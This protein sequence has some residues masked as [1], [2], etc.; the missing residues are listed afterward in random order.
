VARRVGRVERID[1]RVHDVLHHHDPG[2]DDRPA[3]LFVDDDDH[4]GPLDV[5]H[6]RP[7]DLEHHHDDHDTNDDD[8]RP[9]DLEHHH[10]DHGTHD[11]DHHLHHGSG[12]DHPDHDHGPTVGPRLPR[13]R[14]RRADHAAAVGRFSGAGRRTAAFD[15]VSG[16]RSGDVLR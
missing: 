1:G 13:R 2:D 9:A 16:R 11:D 10:D 6:V 15:H 3:G 12:L 4:D 5:D 14:R 8:N 7:A